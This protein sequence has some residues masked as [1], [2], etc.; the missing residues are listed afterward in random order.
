MSDALSNFGNDTIK[1]TFE[2]FYSPLNFILNLDG[3]VKDALDADPELAKAIY[4]RLN[5]IGSD[6]EIEKAQIDTQKLLDS[7]SVQD[8]ATF[9]LNHFVT[10]RFPDTAFSYKKVEDLKSDYKTFFEKNS[11]AFEPREFDGY[12]H[13]MAP[14]N[15]FNP[16][17]YLIHPEEAQFYFPKGARVVVDNKTAMFAV[18]VLN[19]TSE[20][21]KSVPVLYPDDFA[22]APKPGA[23]ECQLLIAP[24]QEDLFKKIDWKVIDSFVTAW[25]D[26]SVPLIGLSPELV[27]AIYV[28]KG[29]TPDEACKTAGVKF[30]QA[31]FLTQLASKPGDEDGNVTGGDPAETPTQS[32]KPSTEGVE[33]FLKDQLGEEIA[34][35][36]LDFSKAVF[37]KS[38]EAPFDAAYTFLSDR[39]KAAGKAP[40]QFKKED[41]A[42]FVTVPAREGATA[43][44]VAMDAENEV[45]AYSVRT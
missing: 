42:Y 11:G 18:D 30:P 2:S 8:R 28:R 36:D 14:Y 23:E 26:T 22:T 44:L 39:L 4:A 27:A 33:Q 17:K 32:V 43:H 24:S 31:D 7:M 19:G 35:K 20:S 45:L 6:F 29:Q 12:P 13:F 40:D 41:V 9:L 10:D 1:S 5:K 3:K 25:E 38:G 37:S 16:L 34:K 15:L 21:K